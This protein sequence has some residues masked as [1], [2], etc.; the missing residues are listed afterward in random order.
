MLTMKKKIILL[1]ALTAI[2]VLAVSSV[3]T[4]ATQKTNNLSVTASVAARCD[5][6]SVTD[7]AFTG[8]DS[9][10]ET[11]DDQT[12]NITL[13]CAKKTM[14]K[15]FITGT[16]Q[17][18]GAT[19]SENLN[20]E[21]YSDS[22]RTVVF[23]STNGGAAVQAPSSADIPNTLYGRIPTLQDVSVDSYAK[24]LIATVEY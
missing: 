19:Y 7:I 17:M 5:I 24:S 6:K 12:G 1:V 23:P 16:R 8:Y 9:W 4:A 11:P 2:V 21:I 18:L 15:L 14:Y 20:F 13:K 10:S 22:G 3:S